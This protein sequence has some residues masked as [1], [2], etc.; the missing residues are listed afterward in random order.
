MS[1]YLARLFFSILIEDYSG[2]EQFDEQFHLISAENKSTAIQKGIDLGSRIQEQFVNSE[3]K[4]VNWNFID[5]TEVVALDEN[6]TK[7]L[8][9]SQHH[10]IENPLPFLLFQKEKA[11]Q[12][13]TS[14]IN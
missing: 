5:L 7:S 10:E 6:P 12:M 13:G 11:M 2:P 3:G 4:L 14:R 8:I 1:H 9:F